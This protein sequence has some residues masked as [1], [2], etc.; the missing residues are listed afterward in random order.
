MATNVSTQSKTPPRPA[1]LAP[2]KGPARPAHVAETAP[3][4][5]PSVDPKL[6]DDPSTKLSQHRTRLSTHRTAL[7]EHRTQLSEHRTDLSTHR[8]DLSEHRTD[9]SEHRTDLSE[10]RTEMSMRRTGMSFQ[11]TRLS[12]ERTLMSVIRTSL[13][14][15][16][17]GFTIYQVF[18][19][20]TDHQLLAGSAPAR[21]FGVLLVILGIAMLVIGILYHVMFMAGLRRERETMAAEGLIHAQS[22]F[23]P[24]MTLVAAVLLL[25]VGL[26]A[27]ANMVFHVSFLG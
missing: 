16:S 8:T 17:F 21:N 6:L 18:Q 9:L 3:P 7:S 14:L 27:I 15:I 4:P 13:S 23:P 5:V 19:K 11:R 25:L 22:G 26:A 20:M 10:N 12:A 1:R 2:W 24:S